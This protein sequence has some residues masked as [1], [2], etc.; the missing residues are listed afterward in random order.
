MKIVSFRQY[1]INLMQNC[2]CRENLDPHGNA[3][4]NRIY[5]VLEKCHLRDMVLSLGGLDVHVLEGGDS[6]SLGQ[7]QLLCLARSFLKSTKVS[8]MF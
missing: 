8:F 1:C 2:K 6:F 4:D 5:E 3:R 7:R